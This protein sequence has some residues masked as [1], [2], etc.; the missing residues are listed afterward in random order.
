MKTRLVR[1]LL[2]VPQS[3]NVTNLLIRRTNNVHVVLRTVLYSIM[4]TAGRARVSKS[5]HQKILLEKKV[6]LIKAL[7]SKR[8]SKTMIAKST[9]SLILK[10]KEKTLEV[11][12][13]GPG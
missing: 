4:A 12:E 2:V 1:T 8:K 10:N 7:E 11:F 6:A 3:K 5:C 9:V 13:L